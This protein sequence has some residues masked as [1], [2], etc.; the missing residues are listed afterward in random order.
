MEAFG[1]ALYDQ[2]IIGNSIRKNLPKTLKQNGQLWMK[3]ILP[4]IKLQA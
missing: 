3:G 1:L 4:A 2:N